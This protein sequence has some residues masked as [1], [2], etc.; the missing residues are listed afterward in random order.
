[1]KTVYSIKILKKGNDPACVHYEVIEG[2]L[3]TCRLCEQV[4]QYYHEE[5]D[6]FDKN[7]PRNLQGKFID[8]KGRRAIFSEA[9]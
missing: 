5:K 8:K 1:M 3:G 9:K 2:N 6:F 7:V 4:K